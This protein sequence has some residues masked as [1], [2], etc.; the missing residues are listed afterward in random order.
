MEILQSL[1]DAATVKVILMIPLPQLPMAD[2][3]IWHYEP[4][5]E[6][7][8]K[9][10]YHVAASEFVRNLSTIPIIFDSR[11]WKAL[12]ALSVPP[13]LR[14]FLWR[15]I[16]GF[17]P[18]RDVLRDKELIEEEDVEGLL[19][20]VCSHPKETL[21]HCFLECRIATELWE[22]AGFG[23]LFHHLNSLHVAIGWRFL[24]LDV[25]LSR[26]EVT[27]L[28]FLYWRIWK[29]RCSSTYE[30]IQFLPVSL[31]RQFNCQTA[32]WFSAQESGT[33]RRRQHLPSPTACRNS[34]P[35]TIPSGF[36]LVHFDGATKESFGGAIGFVGFAS[37]NVVSFA[38]GR[39]YAEV[40]DPFLI[41]LLALRDAMRWCLSHSVTNVLFCGDAQVFIR[42][43][44]AKD[45]N[46]AL[47]GAILNEV[48]VLRTSLAR[49][50]FHFAP[51][52]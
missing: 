35:P 16:K 34:T 6:Y 12:W 8:V 51:R 5:S 31:L 43:V 1:F 25:G 2:K 36:M 19:C 49:V 46:H 32:E 11:A 33:A 45:S 3:L 27:R 9:P 20:P 14:F 52:R 22:L 18:V 24:L 17:L 13:K 30:L 41:E 50:L 42:M 40:H 4:S 47:G 7:S 44:S 37:Q 23:H 15:L 39:S 10:G 38:Y 21:S 26:A 28:V 29:G 48:Q